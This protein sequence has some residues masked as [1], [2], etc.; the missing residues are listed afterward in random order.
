G[1]AE[2]AKAYILPGNWSLVFSGRMGYQTPNWA[3]YLN[4]TRITAEGRFLMPR[5]WGR[6]PFY[7]FLARER[8]EGFGDL[9]AISANLFITPTPRL[10]AEVSL[11]YYRLPDVKSAVLN[12]YGMPTYTQTNIGA[13]YRF[14]GWLNGFDVQTLWII[15]GSVGDTY[16]NARYVVNKVGMSQLNLIVNYH[17]Y[18]GTRI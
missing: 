1:N 9:T 6:D 13:T 14:N 5:E 11:G 10:K 8:N 15:K 7:T 4:A 3:T 17:L 18:N 12:K 16:N 2:P